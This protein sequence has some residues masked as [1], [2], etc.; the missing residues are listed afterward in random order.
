MGIHK[1]G[2]IMDIKGIINSIGEYWAFYGPGYTNH[3]PMALIALQQLGADEKQINAFLT[4]YMNQIVLEK[5]DSPEPIRT[6]KDHLGEREYFQA[7]SQFFIEEIERKSLPQVVTDTLNALRH[8][9]SSALYHGIIRINY[10]LAIQDKEEVARGLALLA[11]AYEAIEFD[12]QIIMPDELYSEITRY[13]VEREG[14]FYLNGN[15]NQKIEAILEGLN[16]LYVKTGSFIVLHTITGF[17]ALLSLRVYFD[18][19]SHIID[20]F[21]VSVLRVLLRISAEDYHDIET[22]EMWPWDQVVEY[23]KTCDNAHTIKFV[24]SLRKLKSR[25]PNIPLLKSAMLKLRMD[26]FL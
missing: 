23:V 20:L 1:L 21:M 19:F 11:S 4:H 26:H 10:A 6:L 7:Y 24:Y 13:I 14:L 16:T 3:L 5:V 18:D 12:G 17:E 8:G 22:S 15:I 2:G 9:I 25:Y